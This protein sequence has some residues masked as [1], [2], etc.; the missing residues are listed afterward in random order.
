MNT[1]TIQISIIAE[2]EGRSA[3]DAH[4]IVTL[5]TEVSPARLL[6]S[7]KPMIEG[8]GAP[9][10]ALAFAPSCGRTFEHDDGENYV[11]VKRLGPWHWACLQLD[12]KGDPTNIRREIVFHHWGQE[13]RAGEHWPD[14]AAKLSWPGEGGGDD[15][16]D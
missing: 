16:G 5:E 12:R 6:K 15:A 3:G 11:I 8:A 7:F 10:V 2:H 1:V 4:G 9:V 13:Y 14:P